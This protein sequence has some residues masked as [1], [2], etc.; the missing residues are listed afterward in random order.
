[1]Y[2]RSTLDRA[3]RGRRP[4]LPPDAT[5][6]G[7]TLR[8]S[9]QTQ[10]IRRTARVPRSARP[11]A[12]PVSAKQAIV[13]AQYAGMRYPG[14]LGA[15]APG[16]RSLSSG[17]GVPLRYDSLQRTRPS[18]TKHQQQYLSMARGGRTALGSAGS[19]R[20][21]NA[22][23]LYGMKSILDLLKP[24]LLRDASRKIEEQE[25]RAQRAAQR[26]EEKAR[27][28]AAE[29]EAR[30]AK[31]Q[32]ALRARMRQVE[33]EMRKAQEEAALNATRFM[34]GATMNEA[35]Q[36]N[37][38]GAAD[39]VGQM[40]LRPQAQREEDHDNL[41]DKDDVYIQRL[42][43]NNLKALVQLYKNLENEEERNEFRNV[44]EGRVQQV[45]AR[46]A[47]ALAPDASQE[48]MDGMTDDQRREARITE[49][50]RQ[51]ADNTNRA[52]SIALEKSLEQALQES[53]EAV[54]L[55]ADKP[56]V[57]AF[58]GASGPA[59]DLSSETPVPMAND[60]DDDTERINKEAERL[61]Q[62]TRRIKGL[63]D[64][65][66]RKRAAETEHEQLTT[67]V[68]PM[69]NEFQDDTQYALSETDRVKE[70]TLEMQALQ[71]ARSQYHAAHQGFSEVQGRLRQNAGN[72]P[73]QSNRQSMLTA[74]V[75]DIVNAFKGGGALVKNAMGRRKRPPPTPQ[76][77]T[78]EAGPTPP[79]SGP[80]SDA[81][82]SEE[83]SDL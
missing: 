73:Q 74:A 24:N 72:T 36:P 37:T 52:K 22:N 14:A 16:M 71:R 83:E 62:E 67:E 25:E 39:A 45:E 20:G 61:E 12:P 41:T 59:N 77:S 50:Q 29:A 51:I 2:P 7:P 10:A 79:P 4:V 57:P 68:T 44:H 31:E 60:Y 5:I 35:G 55:A 19:Y 1:M 56:F 49:L 6:S 75:D 21:A 48:D 34:Q 38:Q 17:Y 26:M 30:A 13:A 8:T 47:S 28:A 80:M 40:N 3:Q 64:A 69:N 66:A 53:A 15:F 81:G 11:G 42:E 33:E 32:E 9:G 63:K 54:R 18:S 27:A 70:R 58:G 46:R 76:L 23:S 65:E 43:R 78:P 82:R